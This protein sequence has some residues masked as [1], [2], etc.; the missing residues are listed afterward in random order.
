VHFAGNC[1]VLKR[2]PPLRTVNIVGDDRVAGF[3]NVSLNYFFYFNSK[4]W[5]AKM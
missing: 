3:V 1:D 5:S 4:N 2:Q